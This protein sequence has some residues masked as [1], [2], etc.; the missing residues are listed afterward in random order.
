MVTYNWGGPG[1][2]TYEVWG[3][4][5]SGEQQAAAA[6]MS[7]ANTMAS[8][9]SAMLGIMNKQMANYQNVFNYLMPQYKNMINN[10]QG[11]G[12]QALSLMKGSVINTVGT[13]LAGQQQ[14]LRQQFASQNMA[15]LG[16]GVQAAISSNMAQQAAG[17]EASAL[18]NIDIQNAQLKA[19]QQQYALGGMAQLGAG[20]GGMATQFGGMGM[21]GMQGAMQGYQSAF[22][23]QYT[24]QQQGN[25]W[26][27]LAMG[28][29][30]GLGAMI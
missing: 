3:K 7:M 19:Q 21:Q 8:Q 16:S 11:F 1:Y 24:M 17:S 20:A 14:Q 5:S 25:F 30:G 22:Q 26:S 27:N 10:P 6:Q 29:L 2:A 18:S 13:Q 9:S 28:A 4:V 12:A 23:N 15:G